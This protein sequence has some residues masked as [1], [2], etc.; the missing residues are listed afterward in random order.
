MPSERDNRMSLLP[1][2]R[3][4]G[5]VHAGRLD[6]HWLF[7]SLDGLIEKSLEERMVVVDLVEGE[8]GRLASAGGVSCRR[9]PG[10]NAEPRKDRLIP[11]GDIGFIVRKNHEA[12]SGLHELC[13]AVGLRRSE[14][15]DSA[16]DEDVKFVDVD[17]GEL[18]LSRLCRRE[19]PCEV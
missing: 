7:L 13:N 4:D 8:K 17:R 12:S 10:R 16:E 3:L 1:G 2:V 15:S 5:P 6:C 11:V 14:F 18:C 9:F 19:Q